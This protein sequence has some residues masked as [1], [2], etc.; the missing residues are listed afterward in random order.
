MTERKIFYVGDGTLNY[1]RQ[2]RRAIA[3]TFSGPLNF[4]YESSSDLALWEIQ[5][6]CFV[7]D[8]H[9]D[10]IFLDFPGSIFFAGRLREYLSHSGSRRTR[11]VLL[12][13]DLENE[14]RVGA[15][16]AILSKEDLV[17]SLKRLVSSLRMRDYVE[18]A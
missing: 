10:L 16:D 9:Y 13:D 6:A 2:F 17:P 5:C 18:N 7:R 3:R 11:I 8:D 1:L 4:D 15:V 14:V 12:S